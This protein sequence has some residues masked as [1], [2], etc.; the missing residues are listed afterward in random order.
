M[1]RQK[2]VKKMSLIKIKSISKAETLEKWRDETVVNAAQIR[3]ALIDLNAF[4]AID[5]AVKSAD[6]ATQ[7]M[8]EFNANVR[9]NNPELIAMAKSL[10]FSDEQIDDV[11]KLALTK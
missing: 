1:S 4:D 7:V 10:N 3:L 2:K 9:R 11:F 6:K 5:N 8:W